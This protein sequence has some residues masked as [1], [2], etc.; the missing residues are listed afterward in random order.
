MASVS[1][2]YQILDRKAPVR[3]V[4]PGIAKIAAGIQSDAQ[5]RTP[6]DTGRLRSGWRVKK[7]RDGRYTVTNAVPYARFVEHGTSDTPPHP[8]LAPATMAARAR[9]G[10]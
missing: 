8:M 2:T 3:A 5:A 10:R 9:Y 4:D 7:D 6:V 1:S